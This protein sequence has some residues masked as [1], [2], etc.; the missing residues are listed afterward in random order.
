MKK[1]VIFEPGNIIAA[2]EYIEGT[3]V[4]MPE[5]KGIIIHDDTQ[6]IKDMLTTCGVTDFSLLEIFEQQK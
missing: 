5:G 1:I 3:R 4:L 2:T 6:I